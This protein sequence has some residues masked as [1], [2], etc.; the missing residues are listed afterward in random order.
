MSDP[1]HGTAL[2]GSDGA[3]G[4]GGDGSH[5]VERL[6]AVWPAVVARLPAAD[7]SLS[8]KVKLWLA[9]DRVR[10][11]G[12]RDGV[13]HLDCPTVLF[14]VQIR[15]L[16]D[17]LAAAASAEL[18]MPVTGVQ[19]RVPRGMAAAHQEQVERAAAPLAP[20]SSFGMGYKALADFVVG[21]CNRLAHAAIQRLLDDPRTAASPLFIHGASGL[22]KTHLE[23]GLALAFKERHPSAQ[24]LY[25]RCE[26][27]TNDFVEAAGANA[28]RA[29]RVRMRHPDLLLIDDLHWL[30]QGQK[31]RTKD[32]LLATLEA[33]HEQGKR[34]VITSDAGPR[35]IKFLEERL[36]Q[37]FSAGLVVAL[38]RPDPQVRRDV[39][40][41]R[42]VAAGLELDAG[43]IDFVVDRFTDNMRQLE[44]A[45]H[46]LD[47]VARSLGRRGI[48]LSAAR[49][50]LADL[51]TGAAASPEDL[52]L[53]EVC[54][55]FQVEPR[56]VRG[57][58][59]SRPVSTARHVALYVLKM[60]A[61]DTYAA[62][63]RSLGLRSHASVVAACERVA[64]LRAQ[65]PDLDA[66]IEDLAWRA[67]RR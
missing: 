16:A 38:D 14:Q 50:S 29:F 31:T 42:A 32:E 19:C 52:V 18:G 30:S 1:T 67:R 40:L 53:T 54:A 59:R 13:L 10:P 20:S 8:A 11:S 21:S 36:V 24:V 4:A 28:L 15:T 12:L 5:V 6:A 22:G 58:G 65:D 62:V 41:R 61:S 44:G 27:F 2:P 37:R 47:A 3:L 49:G 25:L 9:A 45:V 17:R 33:L 23:Q 55:R 64:Q 35:D 7:P 46:R 63:G 56:M 34:V 26:Q 48:D 51:L 43:V 39:V 57:R 66:F 60:A